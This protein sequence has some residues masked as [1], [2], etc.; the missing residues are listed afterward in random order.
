MFVLDEIHVRGDK[1]VYDNVWAW[2]VLENIPKV[3]ARL[4][5]EEP[6]LVAKTAQGSPTYGWQTTAGGMVDTP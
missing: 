3:N 1:I 2:N 6:M 4:L 5:E